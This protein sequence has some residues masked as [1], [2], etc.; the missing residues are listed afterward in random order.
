MPHSPHPISITR[1]NCSLSSEHCA[2]LLPQ[3]R[4]PGLLTPCSLFLGV[5]LTLPP[6]IG[7][8]V[9]GYPEVQSLNTPSPLAT[10]MPSALVQ[11]SSLTTMYAGGFQWGWFCPPRDIWQC[12]KACLVVTTG[13]RFYFQRGVEAR[14]AAEH[15]EMH[16]TTKRKCPPQPKSI[17][18]KCQQCQGWETLIWTLGSHAQLPINIVIRIFNR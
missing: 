5:L 3:A 13:S 2:R 7:L 18:P 4:S 11:Y 16:R 15:P 10:C 1:W 6:F 17:R 9:S 8:W 12:L 14:A